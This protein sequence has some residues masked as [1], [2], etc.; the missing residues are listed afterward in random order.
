[1]PVS[2]RTVGKVY[3]GQDGTLHRPSTLL[4]ITLG[5]YGRCTPE[6]GPVADT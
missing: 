6:R 4:T 5:S 2:R 3:T 1:M